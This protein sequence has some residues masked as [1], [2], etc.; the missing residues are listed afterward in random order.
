[1]IR[2]D[3]RLFEHF[4]M[5]L[6]LLIFL[7]CMMA[8]FNLY[9]ASSPPKGYGMAP[10]VKQGYFFLMAFTAFI[11]V[12]S[13]DYQVLHSWN[14]PIYV[15]I[16]VLLVLAET[17]GNT[18]GGAQ[19]W[20][21]LGFFKL[22]PSE[23]A[24]LMLI[25]TLASYFSRK[26]INEGYSIKDLGS[27]YTDRAP[28]Y[29]HSPAAGPWNSD[30]AWHNLC[31]HGHVRETQNVH[32]CHNGQFGVEFGHF[33]LGKGVAALSK[34]ENLHIPRTRKRSDGPWLSGFAIEDRRRQWRQIRQRVYGRYPGPF[35][36]L[37]GTAHRFRL[38]RL[39]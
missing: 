32:L 13:F 4:D 20:I 35:A 37:A 10:Y 6:M 30:D 36:F 29:S 21:N 11:F 28:F 5:V 27:G 12:I 19:R 8:F 1:M 26:E 2:I 16:I 14:Y 38:L 22:Q 31:V 33:C 15:V 17:I 23:P 24:K 7:V 39:G 34:T 3:R 25:I 9:S 18:A